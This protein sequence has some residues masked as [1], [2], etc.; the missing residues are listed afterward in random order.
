[1]ADTEPTQRNERCGCIFY[2]YADG[3]T[4]TTPCIPHGFTHIAKGL[5]L[6]AEAMNT[7]ATRMMQ[8]AEAAAKKGPRI[9]I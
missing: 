6:A 9:I 8:E 5:T 2:D 3:R 7:M 4:E 1:M